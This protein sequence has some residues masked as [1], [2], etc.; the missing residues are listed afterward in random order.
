VFFF[1]FFFWLGFFGWVFYCQPWLQEE[2]HNN[3]SGEQQLE[4]EAFNNVASGIAASLGLEPQQQQ[5]QSQQQHQPHIIIPDQSG[6]VP[7]STVP[8]SV[9]SMRIRIRSIRKFLGL[10]DPDPSIV[11]KK[12]MKNLEPKT[13]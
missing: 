5:Q 6:V 1:F 9:L 3:N 4:T 12:S 11:K 2:G 13:C 8:I 10:P 7:V